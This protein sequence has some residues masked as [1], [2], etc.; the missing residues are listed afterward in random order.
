MTA[1]PAANPP[2]EVLPPPQE[3]ILEKLGFLYLS[4]FVYLLISRVLDLF[5]SSLHLPFISI[6]L[7]AFSAIVSG[8]II[9]GL[10]ST[11]GVLYVV[12]TAL[13]LAGLPFAFWRGGSL[14]V[15]K[16]SWLF[17]TLAAWLLIAGMPASFRQSKKLLNVLAY[18]SITAAILGVLFGRISADGRLAVVGGRLGN[19]NDYGAT[20]LL[21]LPFIWRLYASQTKGLKKLA[22]GCAALPVLY[23]LVRSG[24]REILLAFVVLILLAIWRAPMMTKMK[25]IVALAACGAVA[26]AIMPTAV[27]YRYLTL[28]S[29]SNLEAQSAEEELAI[30]YATSST[31]SRK[32][33]VKEAISIALHH[34][35]FGVGMGNFAPFSN[36]QAKNS[37]RRGQWLGTHNTYLQIASEDGIPALCVFVAIFLLSWRGLGKLIRETKRDPRPGIRDI[38]RTAVATQVGLGAF[39][40]FLCFD[41]MGYDIWCHVYTACAVVVAREGML[42]LARLKAAAA[43]R[44]EPR[45]V[46]AMLRTLAPYAQ[47]S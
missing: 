45:P 30:G 5:L 32:Q 21:G 27:R 25:S 38:Y 15:F 39:C 12:L 20:L 17:G 19:P 16:K 43:V 40:F 44:V 26:F 18:A 14:T 28:G 1:V 4:I 35:V 22:V 10:K 3:S 33:L 34:P 46:P 37:G 42:E 47:R 6:C 36:D 9:N 41:H 13:F 8:R 2:L 31:A 29:S 7:A 11:V 23:N 24:S